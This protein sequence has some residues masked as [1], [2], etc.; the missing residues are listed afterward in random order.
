MNTYTYISIN[1]HIYLYLY[2]YTYMDTYTYTYIHT[3][4]YTYNTHA[5]RTQPSILLVPH[6]TTPENTFTINNMPDV[7][8][9][10]SLTVIRFKTGDF[11]V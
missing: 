11:V 5:E 3:Y 2:T 1:T 6:T 4:A 9:T 7:T 8:Q 10:A